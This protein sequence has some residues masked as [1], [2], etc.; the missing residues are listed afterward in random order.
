MARP[1][2]RIWQLD[3]G[4]LE[5]HPDFCSSQAPAWFARLQRD[6]PWNTEEL[7]AFGRRVPSPRLVAFAGESGVNYRYSGLEH[8]ATGWV[9]VLAEIRQRVEAASGHAFNWV[10]GNLYRDGRDYMGWHADDEASLGPDPVVA[11]VSLGAPRDFVLRRRDDKSNKFK[12][13]LEDGSLLLM[14]GALQ[15]HWQHSLPR[16]LRVTGPRINLTFRQVLDQ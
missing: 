5:Y 7:L 12:L 10:L 14:S 11:S 2:P 15:H 1:A 6:L 8:R 16:R 13:L 4:R 3:D 9:S